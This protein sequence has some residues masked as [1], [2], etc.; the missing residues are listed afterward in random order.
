MTLDPVDRLTIIHVDFEAGGTFTC[1]ACGAGGRKA[2]D[3]KHK[4][5]RHL[6][7]LGHRTFLRGPSPRV[8]CAS[9]GI[10]QAELPWA[11]SRQRLTLP[12]EE[13]VVSLAREMPVRA[14][15]SS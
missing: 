8:K 13:M 2:Y 14:V 4:E 7:F 9:C 6:D 12:F 1:G 15:A 10:R 5:W 11:R 3:T